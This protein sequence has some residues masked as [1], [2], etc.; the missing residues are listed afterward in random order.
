MPSKRSAGI[1]LYRRRSA[2]SEVLLVHPGGPFW[3]KKDLGAWF[4]PKGELE[5]EEEPL[6]AAR[7]EFFE[8]LGSQPPA[9][10]PLELGT[11][12]NKSGKLIYAWALEGD[13]DLSTFKSNTF[14]LE[15]PPR[16]GKMRD[17][18]EIDRAQ[19]FPMEVAADKLHPAELPLLLRLQEL[20]QLGSEPHVR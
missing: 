12:K 9:G 7:R 16:S 3:S 18:P 19:F 5:E 4:I 15:W 13:L 11:V 1:L 17:F 2:Q 8:E 6:A 14:A 20:A 10:E